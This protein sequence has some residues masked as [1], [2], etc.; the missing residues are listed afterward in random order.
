MTVSFPVLLLVGLLAASVATI[1]RLAGTDKEDEQKLKK[2]L[3]WVSMLIGCAFSGMVGLLVLRFDPH[4]ISSLVLK[5]TPQAESIL[6]TNSV[7]LLFGT[8]S[9]PVI[10]DIIFA[11]TMMVLCFL[12]LPM[13]VGI[14]VTLLYPV[15]SHAGKA[16]P[17]R[18]KFRNRV[19]VSFENVKRTF[20]VFSCLRN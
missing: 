5:N 17:T 9:I 1:R 3:R 4:I 16:E 10:L 11:D 12:A 15:F 19:V 14:G 6:L 13:M 20:L 18:N 2:V 7:E 8:T